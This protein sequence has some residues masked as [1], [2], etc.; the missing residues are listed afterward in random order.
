MQDGKRTGNVNKS[1]FVESGI[2]TITYI[3]RFDN[4]IEEDIKEARESSRFTVVTGA[5]KTGK[6]VLVDRFFPNKEHVWIDCGQ[7]DN[8]NDL[9]LNI[10]S[11]LEGST[12]TQEEEIISSSMEQ[13]SKQGLNCRIGAKAGKIEVSKESE[14]S[15]S[16][17][18]SKTHLCSKDYSIKQQSIKLLEECGKAIIL[19]DFHYLSDGIIKT[20]AKSF[21]GAVLRGLTVILITIPS[22]KY[23][24][25]TSLEELRGRSKIIEIPSWTTEELMRIAEVGFHHCGVSFPEEAYQILA[26]DSFGSPAIMQNLCKYVSRAKK[27]NASTSTRVEMADLSLSEIETICRA[28][29]KRECSSLMNR[30]LRGTTKGRQRKKYRLKNGREKDVIGIVLDAFRESIQKGL[31]ITYAGYFNLINNILASDTRIQ[32]GQITRVLS[33]FAKRPKDSGTEKADKNDVF[34]EKVIDWRGSGEPIS[35]LEPYFAFGLKYCVPTDMD[36]C[37]SD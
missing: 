30:L 24:L 2:P 1:V 31:T 25:V 16:K 10:L 20:V 7:I 34:S 21:K 33:D 8:E 36:D 28:F 37:F 35:I 12:S 13:A 6:T 32:R 15:A 9:W 3:S 11:S 4:D 5:T 29:A 22:Q 17:T 27:L 18:L 14:N 23:A 26:S 19:D